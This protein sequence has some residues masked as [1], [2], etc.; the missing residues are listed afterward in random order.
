MVEIKLIIKQKNLNVDMEVDLEARSYSASVLEEQYAF[1]IKE[2]IQKTLASMCDNLE[3]QGENTTKEVVID[4]SFFD[5]FKE[6]SE[7]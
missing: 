4:D 3:V 7:E 5:N 6:I 1:A 2:V